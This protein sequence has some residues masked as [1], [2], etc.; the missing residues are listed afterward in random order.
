M[1]L[2]ENQEWSVLCNYALN[3]YLVGIAGAQ[4]MNEEMNVERKMLSKY[5]CSKS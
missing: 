3:A 4:Y 1:Q 5:A 2:H